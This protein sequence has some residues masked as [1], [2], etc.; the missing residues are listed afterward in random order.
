MVKDGVTATQ[1]HRE[2]TEQASWLRKLSLV[3]FSKALNA[4]EDEDLL[5]L[6]LVNYLH[7]PKIC[8]NCGILESKG[9]KK[10]KFH[11]SFLRVAVPKEFM[12][13]VCGQNGEGLQ[14]I[15]SAFGIRPKVKDSEFWLQGKTSDVKQAFHM[16][17]RRL[18]NNGKAVATW[19]C[20]GLDVQGKECTK[21]MSH[22]FLS[23]PLGKV[24][25]LDCEMVK[26][27]AGKEIARVALLNFS[28]EICID[29]FVK[30]KNEIRDYGTKYSGITVDSLRGIKT[31]LSDVQKSLSRLVSDNDILVGHSIDHDLECLHWGHE[32]VAKKI[33]TK[34]I[35]LSQDNDTS[36]AFPNPNRSKKN[37]PECL[38]QGT[39]RSKDPA[40]N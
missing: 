9:S 39:S 38:G 16:I 15:E 8:Q 7:L 3:N 24:F 12:P 23:Q 25:A 36:I 13:L 33:N 17:H 35:F 27:S 14:Q 29:E 26:T 4:M 28:G 18:K 40:R 34:L 30:P 6:K 20:C 1:F 11:A 32:K 10:C 37:V 22:V 5:Y 21:G 19:D 31:R 2:I